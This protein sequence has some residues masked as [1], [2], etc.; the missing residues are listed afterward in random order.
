MFVLVGSQGIEAYTS[1]W[2]LLYRLGLYSNQS[3]ICDQRRLCE[4]WFVLKPCLLMHLPVKST[5]NES[6]KTNSIFI[7]TIDLSR[8]LG[9]PIFRI[10]RFFFPDKHYLRP[11]SAVAGFLGW[12]QAVRQATSEGATSG[13]VRFLLP[14]GNFWWKGED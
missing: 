14:L 2:G 10:S 11:L 12:G 6:S 3:Q 5:T 9:F 1:A 4:P 13:D 7:I 8:N